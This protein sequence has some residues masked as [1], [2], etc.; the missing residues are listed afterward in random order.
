MVDRYRGLDCRATQTAGRGKTYLDAWTI[1][2]ATWG[3][4]LPIPCKLVI[5][6]A[7][8]IA[9][10]AVTCTIMGMIRARPGWVIREYRPHGGAAFCIARGV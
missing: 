2:L 9:D 3:K 7:T 6:V 1:R 4:I 5:P 8:R 10:V